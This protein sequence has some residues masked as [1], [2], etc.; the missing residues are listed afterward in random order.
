M[1]FRAADLQSLTKKPW[2]SLYPAST[3][4]LVMSHAA[5]R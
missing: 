1:S 3:V 2:P 4:T 5:L